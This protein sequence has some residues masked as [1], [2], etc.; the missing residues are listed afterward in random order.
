MR[1]PFGLVLDSAK[2]LMAGRLRGQRK[3][4]VMLSLDPMGECTGASAFGNGNG[5]GNGHGLGTTPERSMLSVEQC[6]AAMEECDTPIV[7]LRGRE[8][9]EYPEISA[10]TRE[11]VKLGKH[12]FLC[13]DGT[14]I[15]RRLHMIAPYTNF[16]WNVRLD[17]TEAVHDARAKRPG[18]FAEAVDG[19]KAA[20]NAGFFVVVTTTICAD[21]D[22][23]DVARL[24][25]LL[26]LAHVDGY[27]FSP[28]YSTEK[29]CKEG[30]R[31]FHA[32]MEARFREVDGLLG[33][34]NVMTSP[35]Y[36]EYLRGERELGCSSWG[37]P[38][39][40]PE[41][42]SRPCAL[43]KCGEEKSYK[44]LME[45]TVWENFGRGV[46][47]GCETCASHAGYETAA[48]LGVSSRPGD[49]WRMLA[50]QFGGSLGEKRARNG[51]G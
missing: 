42:W 14:L 17:G 12:L 26:H 45:N 29:L 40:G 32:A 43:L 9:L 22:V 30:S 48:L 5:G 28:Y 46:N 37:N 35:I 44:A 16:F 34:Y 19:I 31:K 13:T 49:A 7:A 6:L 23:K 15:R 51:K 20:K 25:E 18:L 38:S 50:W 21:T 10:L 41:G 47:L 11:I 33:D 4:P 39:F 8:P 2:H 3:I 36:M 27:M 1:Y 24:F